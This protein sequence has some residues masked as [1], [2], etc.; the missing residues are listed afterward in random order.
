MH[1]LSLECLQFGLVVAIVA[2]KTVIIWWTGGTGAFLVPISNV[3]R[4]LCWFYFWSRS[5][6]EWLH[7][8]SIW[9]FNF[10]SPRIFWGHF[11]WLIVPEREEGL[12]QFAEKIYTYGNLESHE[13][14]RGRQMFTSDS[15]GI[16]LLVIAIVW[17]TTCILITSSRITSIK[18]RTSRMH[19]TRVILSS[20]AKLALL[21]VSWM[22]FM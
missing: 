13:M 22:V 2:R 15:V 7:I 4:S 6:G 18:G 1:N 19:C 10:S 14:Q 17:C 11:L 12:F 5:D 21:C 9:N 3:G 16:I 20:L 8:R